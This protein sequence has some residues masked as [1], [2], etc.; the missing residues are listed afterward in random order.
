MAGT[1]RSTSFSREFVALFFAAVCLATSCTGGSDTEQQESLNSSD[2]E[3]K[4]TIESSDSADSRSADT[5]GVDRDSVDG[6]TTPNEDLSMLWTELFQIAGLPGEERAEAF[7]AFDGRVPSEF[8]NGIANLAD[9]RQ[10]SIVATSP[11]ISETG[12]GTFAIE[13]CVIFAPPLLDGES[14]RHYSGTAE[15][16]ESDNWVITAIDQNRARCIPTALHDRVLS[17]F[18]A[19]NDVTSEANNPPNPDDP[20]LTQYT[21]GAVLDGTVAT[22]T[23]N[24]DAGQVFVVSLENFF[25]EVVGVYSATEVSIRRCAELA[26]NHGL[27]DSDGNRLSAQFGEPVPGSTLEV[28]YRVSLDDGTWKLSDFESSSSE[29]DSCQTNPTPQGLTPVG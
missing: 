22:L 1:R 27:F 3:A 21:M 10:I 17:D 15:K 8:G 7:G 23:A 6:V 11:T 29:G 13:D 24:R 2:A 20:R 5:D 19:A 14:S 9:A 16:D 25:D 4:P 12:D 26:P 18:R 28:V